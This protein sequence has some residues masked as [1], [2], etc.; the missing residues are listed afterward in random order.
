LRER[1]VR[2]I[3]E[4]ID[5]T[6]GI[7]WMRNELRRFDPVASWNM[8]LP[9]N[10]TETARGSLVQFLESREWVIDLDEFD[11]RPELYTTLE[12]PLWLSNVPKAWL[13][14]PLMLHSEL[15]GFVLLARPQEC[16][17]GRL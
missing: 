8:E 15:I 17:L 5:S 3:A 14:T 1:A 12:Y 11:R 13:I 2:A 6:G 10:A 16:E 4:I 9:A 7:L